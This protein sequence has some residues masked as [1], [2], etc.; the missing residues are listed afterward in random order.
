MAKVLFAVSQQEYIEFVKDDFINAGFDVIDTLVMNIKYLFE[1]INTTNPDIIII[2]EDRLETGID[3]QHEKEQTLVKHIE[4]LRINNPTLR[5]ALLSANEDI[6]P[7]FQRLI[8]MGVHD[9]FAGKKIKIRPMV[10]Q[11][12]NPPQ[13]KNIAKYVGSS[14]PELSA[15]T[16]NVSN[17]RVIQVEEVQEEPVFN[18]EVKKKAPPIKI[19]TK[20]IFIANLDERSGST[21][22]SHILV[23]YLSS[24]GLSI[25]YIESPY[26]EGYTFP[27]FKG[28]SLA[29]EGYVSRFTDV[30]AARWTINNVEYVAKNTYIEN[31][32]SEETIRYGFAEL[33]NEDND[34]VII[35]DAGSDWEKDTFREVMD[36][37]DYVLFVVEPDLVQMMRIVLKN[38]ERYKRAAGII[39]RL[40]SYVIANK[41]SSKLVGNDVI[42]DAYKEKLLTT[43]SNYSSNTVFSAQNKG[44]TIFSNKNAKDTLKEELNPI[45]NLIAPELISMDVQQDEKK[46]GFASIFGFGKKK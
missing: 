31:Q 19:N 23:D 14:L 11:L 6:C 33:L 24:L 22:I 32:F 7:F 44:T 16:H 36:A 1:V 5:V 18:E 13:Y 3:D 39:N 41:F 43:I 35:V 20:K 29:P 4:H 25:K 40:D 9:I 27:L 15:T 38:H 8:M 42:R 30:E 26:S 10:E 21:F 2:H 12:Q 46:G 34:H 17:E 28:Y 37:C 45:V